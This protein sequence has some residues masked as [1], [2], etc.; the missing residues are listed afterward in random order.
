MSFFSK[1]NVSATTTTITTITTISATTTSVVSPKILQQ[2]SCTDS[3]V[4]STFTPK[5]APSRNMKLHAK[6]TSPSPLAS[7]PWASVPKFVSAPVLAIAIPN[8]P[9][10]YDSFTAFPALRSSSIP[11][12]HLPTTQ[13]AASHLEDLNTTKSY[14]HP[15]GASYFGKPSYKNVHWKQIEVYAKEETAAGEANILSVNFSLLF[16]LKWVYTFFINCTLFTLKLYSIIIIKLTACQ[17]YTPK[18]FNFYYL[19]LSLT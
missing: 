15:T 14:I 6:S 7:S 8:T 1:H 11:D 2:T 12:L 17:S 18:Y 5:P 16:S 13:R 10:N 4:I 19:Q 9:T 3:F